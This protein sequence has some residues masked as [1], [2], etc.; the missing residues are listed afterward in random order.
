MVK[1]HIFLIIKYFFNS[2]SP[3]GP[4]TPFATD[5]T[6]SLMLAA[7]IPTITLTAII[8]LL[9]GAVVYLCAARKDRSPSEVFEPYYA[10]IQGSTSAISAGSVMIT[11]L[12]SVDGSIIL[13]DCVAYAEP[14]KMQLPPHSENDDY[15]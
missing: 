12:R 9:G 7:V 3:L 10:E 6:V 14:N 5:D 1:L 8:A 11:P 13:Q 2:F 4:S 15:I